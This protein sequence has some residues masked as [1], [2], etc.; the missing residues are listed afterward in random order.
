MAATQENVGTVDVDMIFA[1]ESYA[2]HMVKPVISVTNKTISLPN[3]A[4][5]PHQNQ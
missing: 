4:A 1:N 5:N 3:A 2:L